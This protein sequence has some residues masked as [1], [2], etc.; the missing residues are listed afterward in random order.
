M[1]NARSD[2]YG[3]SLSWPSSRTPPSLP[4]SSFDLVCMHVW[5]CV[6]VYAWWWLRGGCHVLMPVGLIHRKYEWVW[7]MHARSRPNRLSLDHH[8][9]YLQICMQ[10]KPFAQSFNP[11]GPSLTYGHFFRLACALTL[12]LSLSPSLPSSL[13]PFQAGPT[14]QVLVLGATDIPWKWTP[15]TTTTLFI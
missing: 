11:K 8:H 6:C 10:P 4:S 7:I 14:K 15:P 9:A 2:N 12:P 13:P 5:V 1:E 3:S